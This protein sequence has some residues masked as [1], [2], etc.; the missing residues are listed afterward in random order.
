MPGIDV[1]DGVEY[2]IY[3][4]DADSERLRLSSKDLI[5]HK[6]CLLIHPPTPRLPTL[7]AP[8]PDAG[9]LNLVATDTAC[10]V[11]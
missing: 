1:Q 8:D 3:L 5:I 2:A 4:Q 11:L 6:E 9:R 10:R 7:L